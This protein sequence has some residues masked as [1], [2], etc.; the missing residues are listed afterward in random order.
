MDPVGGTASV[1]T[2]FSCALASTK[3]IYQ[4]ITSIKDGPVHLQAFVRE[5]E[6]LEKVLKQ[7]SAY[8]LPASSSGIDLEI[9]LGL[10]HTC[11]NDLL[12]YK[13]EVTKAVP[14]DGKAR[15]VLKRFRSVLREKHVRRMQQEVH[16]HASKLGHQL[17]H[18][19][20]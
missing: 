18:V 5:V 19:Q 9:E 15:M 3:F 11:N 7:F 2:L 13:D 6:T 12:R 10:V 14:S 20:K 1:L 8:Q 17:S 4:T 16:S